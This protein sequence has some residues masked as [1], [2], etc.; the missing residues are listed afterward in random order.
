MKN[1]WE[2]SLELLAGQRVLEL[3][4]KIFVS[5]SLMMEVAL[6]IFKLL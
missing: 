2:K 1:L 5:L 4:Q 6:K 3:N